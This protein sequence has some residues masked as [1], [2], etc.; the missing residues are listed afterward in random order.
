MVDTSN[1]TTVDGTSATGNR[2]DNT[3]GVIAEFDVLCGITRGKEKTFV[4]L[5]F[6]IQKHAVLNPIPRI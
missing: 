4:L 5:E 6:E 1:K 3:K 2:L